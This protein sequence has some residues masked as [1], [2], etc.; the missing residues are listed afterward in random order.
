MSD[1]HPTKRPDLNFDLLT[2]VLGMKLKICI[3]LVAALLEIA[4]ILNTD[5]KLFLDKRKSYYK[6]MRAHFVVK[7]VAE[8]FET[9]TTI[10][11]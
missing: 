6:Y 1:A 4:S 9:F 10:S 7:M 8:L 5:C 2:G 3:Q 11:E